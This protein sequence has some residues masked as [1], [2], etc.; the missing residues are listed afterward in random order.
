VFTGGHFTSLRLDG[1]GQ[2]SVDP[3]GAAARFVDGLSN[4]D[5]GASAVNILPS[6]QISL[7]APAS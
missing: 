6:G 3:S 4:A 2:P 7:P 5:F 1:V